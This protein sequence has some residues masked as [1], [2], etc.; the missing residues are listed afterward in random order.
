[1]KIVAIKQTVTSGKGPGVFVGSPLTQLDVEV[2]NDSSADL[3]LDQVVV[4]MVYGSPQRLAAAVYEDGAVD[5]G[6]AVAG[7]KSKTGRYMF[8]VPTAQLSR[9]S[10]NVDF[11]GKHAA[12]TFKGSVR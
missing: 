11:D 4:S 5:L 9:V 6:G 8:S 12:A 1:M 7:G 3:V 2:T 10:L